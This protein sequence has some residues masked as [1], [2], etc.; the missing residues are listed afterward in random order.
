[1]GHRGEVSAVWPRASPVL[2]EVRGS[3]ALVDEM[4]CR[5]CDKVLPHV[6]PLCDDGQDDGD[7]MCVVCGAAVTVSGL[8]V[9]ELRREQAA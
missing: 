5:D 8:L 3:V 2:S 9:G 7:L 1:M 4:L 6:A